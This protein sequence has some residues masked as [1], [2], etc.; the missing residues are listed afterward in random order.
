VTGDLPLDGVRIVELADIVAGPSVG[1]LLGDFGAD[2]VKIERLEGGDAARRMGAMLDDRSAWWA[3]LGRNK[4]SLAINLKS[5]LG[6]EALL[7]LLDTADA[8]VE[9]YRPGVLE[10]LGLAPEDL[11]ARNDRLVIVRISG[12]GQT[13]PRSSQPGLGTLA[14]AYSGFASITGQADGPPTLPP[15]ALGDESAALFATWSLLAALYWRDARGGTGQVID[16][17]LFESLYSL[18]GPLPTLVKHLGQRPGRLGSRLSFSSPRNVYATSDDRWIALSGT[19]PS[20]ARRLLEVLG[21]E[22]VADERFRTPAGRQQHADDLDALVARWIRQRTAAE[23]ERE[24]ERMGVAMSRVFSVHETVGD[25]H[26]VARGTL[27]EVPDDELGR[28]TMQAPVPRMSRTP[29]RIAWAGPRLGR[30]TEHVLRDLGFSDDEVASGASAGAW[31]ITAPGDEDSG[32][33]S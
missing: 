12:F 7:R 1:A 11:L 16:V 8:L 22:V 26:Y 32:E 5:E 4:R 21:P 10:G 31:S 15:V 13:G 23:V 19:A 17:S 6:R 27:A 18:L 20:R 9:A 3:M 29:G 14:E 25:P 28:V 30:D 2:V 24:L 33:R